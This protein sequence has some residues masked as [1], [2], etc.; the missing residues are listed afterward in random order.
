MGEAMPDRDARGERGELEPI[1]E[2]LRTNVH[3]HGRRYSAEQLCERVT[4]QG[5]NPEPLMAYLKDKVDR[6]YG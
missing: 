4:G 2:W 6:V 1:R 3:E 5:M